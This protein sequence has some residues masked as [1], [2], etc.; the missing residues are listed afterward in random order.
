V[1]YDFRNWTL[2]SSGCRSEIGYVTT[3]AKFSLILLNTFRE[4]DVMKKS[5]VYDV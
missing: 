5:L 3:I 4:G 2:I 1:S